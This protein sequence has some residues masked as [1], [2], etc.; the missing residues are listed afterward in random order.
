MKVECLKKVLDEEDYSILTSIEEFRYIN[1]KEVCYLRENGNYKIVYLE[2]GTKFRFGKGNSLEPDMPECIDCTIT[3]VCNGGCDYCYLNCNPNGK[4][5]V[6]DYKLLSQ[7]PKYTELAINVNDMS[8]PFL[9]QFLRNMSLQDIFVNVTINQKH[10]TSDI[11]PRLIYYRNMKMIRGLGISF[12][13]IDDKLLKYIHALAGKCVVVHVIA[14]ILTKEEYEWLSG[15]GL[16]LLIL[17]YKNIGK[18]IEYYNVNKEEIE[19]NMKDLHDLLAKDIHNQGF[20]SI[21]F[22][23]LSIEQLDVKS[24]I[25][26]D[27]YKKMYT[28]D[29]GSYSF[30]LDLVNHKYGISS[31]SDE[32]RDCGNLTIKEMF[33]SIRTPGLRN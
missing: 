13:K 31:I 5:A 24:I 30:Y 3:T 18:G 8:H 16:N 19:K 22:D 28:G 23:G 7:I 2:D 1:P 33:D 29:E 10:L 20:K 26:E 11:V 27:E 17:G 6:F 9:K 12:T 25:G 14:G 32:Y 4:H 21:A 15:H